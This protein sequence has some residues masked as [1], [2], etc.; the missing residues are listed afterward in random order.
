MF[1]ADKN[2]YI[3]CLFSSLG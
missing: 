1:E 3:C 2:D